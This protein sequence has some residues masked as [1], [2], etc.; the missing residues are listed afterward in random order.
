MSIIFEVPGKV[1]G[2]Q[3]PLVTK[4]GTFTPKQTV[5]AEAT[6]KLFARQAGCEP[7]INPIAL[8]VMALRQI[9]KSFSKS[10]RIDALAGR[11]F[12]L[13]PPDVDNTDKLVSDALNW[14]AYEDDRQIVDS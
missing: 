1:R 9:P 10:K 14:N 13:T 3:R 7:N 4:H 11:I 12:P 8:D 6:I 5:N 2:K